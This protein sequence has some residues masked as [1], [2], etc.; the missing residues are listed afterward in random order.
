[1]EYTWNVYNLER[2]LSDGLVFEV[3]Y[4]C[5]AQFGGEF[6][7]QIYSQTFVGSTS[8]PGFIPYEDLTQDDV[9]GWIYNIVD[10]SSIQLS[11][12]ASLATI[13]S[14][15]NSQTVGEGVPWGS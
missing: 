3:T 13:I 8:E 5:I 4:G 7:R 14:S 12:S 10:T 11:T 15:S 6:T 1:M 2:Q 9:L